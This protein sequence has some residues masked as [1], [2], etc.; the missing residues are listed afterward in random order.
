M[1]RRRRLPTYLFA[2]VRAYMQ[3]TAGSYV[4]HLQKARFVLLPLEPKASCVRDSSQQ[5]DIAFLFEPST[6]L[7]TMQSALRLSARRVAA[8]ASS[9]GTK[10]RNTESTIGQ[11]TARALATVPGPRLFD[12]E[13]VRSVLKESDAIEAIE[14]A[15]GMLAKGKVDVPIP[16]HIG[17]DESDK[18]GP[19]DCHI[20]GGYIFG[21][22]TWTVKL[23]NVSFYKNLEKVCDTY[24]R[25]VSISHDFKR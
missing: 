6:A 7:S 14:N 11:S 21:T 5:V 22:T 2:F 20:K 18:A 8:S 19:G 16:M 25:R 1:C 12:Y 15:F 23:A 4:R 9:S 13:T 10:L 3:P 24:F 17:I